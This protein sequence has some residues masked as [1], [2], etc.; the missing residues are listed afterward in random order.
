MDV[1]RAHE[2]TASDRM[3]MARW[4]DT[5]TSLPAGVCICDEAFR[6]SWVLGWPSNIETEKFVLAE[7]S[8]SVE[9][10][11][12]RLLKECFGAEWIHST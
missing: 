9:E 7:S 5:H 1:Y 4:Q 10:E 6:L 11:I 2:I 12:F 8:S 3:V